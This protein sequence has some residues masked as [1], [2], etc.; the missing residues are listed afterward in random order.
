MRPDN[1]RPCVIFDCHHPKH[2]LAIRRVGE[3]CRSHGIEPIWTIQDKNVLATLGVRDE[4]RRRRSAMLETWG[5]PTEVYWDE[6]C[7]ATAP[8]LEARPT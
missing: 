2:F 3:L 6:L 1:E 8:A 7:T 4:W 5:G